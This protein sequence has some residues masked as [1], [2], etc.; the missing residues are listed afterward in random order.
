MI[1][2]RYIDDVARDRE[3]F[4]TLLTAK[5]FRVEAEAPSANMKTR[6][7][8]D[9]GPDVFLVDYELTKKEKGRET[10]A[11][12]GG[13]LAS[14]IRESC[15]ER[16]IVLFTRESLMRGSYQVAEDVRGSF[17]DIIYK[18]TVERDP[19]RARTIIASLARGFKGL[20]QKRKR[21]WQALFA[22]LDARATEHD[23][24]RRAAPPMSPWAKMGQWRVHEA[25]HW[26]RRVVLEYP[27]IIY[28]ELHAA[29]ALGI[30]T[31]SFGTKRLQSHLTSARYTGVFEEEAPRWWRNRVL[32]LAHQLMAETGVAGP[33]DSQF[34]EAFKRKTGIPLRPSIC[35]FSGERP[36]DCVCYILRKPVKRQYSLLYRPDN[37]PA[38]MEEARVSFKAIR[39]DNRVF[40]ELFDDST[41]TLLVEIRRTGQ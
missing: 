35:V 40:D 18:G 15:P 38:V 12:Q 19:E 2:V 29:T 3:R 39:E 7:I 9:G 24:L 32:G 30:S 16:P 20:R 23:V 4:E 27:G 22:C 13:A 33:V 10:V 6:Q 37:R 17:D 28:D 21:S 31:E 11:Y 34:A 26:I 14:A 5:G 41:Q 1:T 25:S 8:L 36:A